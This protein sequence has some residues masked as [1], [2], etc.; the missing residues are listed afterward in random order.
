MPNPDYVLV[1]RE[2]TPKMIDAT[3]SH[4]EPRFESHNTRNVRIYRAMLA[5]APPP[6]APA[7]EP[8]AWQVRTLHSHGWY[9][10]VTYMDKDEAR[11]VIDRYTHQGTTVE[12]RALYPTPPAAPSP[13]L[14]A[15]LEEL[16]AE[17][18][19]FVSLAD[20]LNLARRLRAILS[21]YMSEQASFAGSEG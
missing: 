18:A 19:Q 10:W 17:I 21:R 5:A 3:W 6:D 15:L 4:D 12:F 11:F 13:E 8:V 16:E 20:P 1:P 9:G 7:P 2:P 14:G